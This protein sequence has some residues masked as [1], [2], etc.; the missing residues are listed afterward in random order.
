VLVPD[1]QGSHPAMRTVM[2]AKPDVLNHN[3]E[4]APRLYRMVRLGARYERSLEMLAYARSV[5]PSIP[6]KSGLMMGLG[7]TNEEVVEVMRDLRAHGVSIFT[8]GQYLRPSPKH[9]P[10]M[11][12]VT[13]EEFAELKKEGLA[14]G[15]E[16][17]EAGPLVRSSYHASEQV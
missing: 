12:Y 2:E 13:P 5:D 14:M 1:F 9:L 3:I 11:R 15:F 17:V 6:T 4:T 16:H 8:L 10:I 7:E